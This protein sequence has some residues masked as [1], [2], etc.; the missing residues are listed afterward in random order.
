MKVR[1][2]TVS[3]A[4][5]L[6]VWS[7]GIAVAQVQEE[8]VQEGIKQEQESDKQEDILDFVAPASEAEA[9]QSQLPLRGTL[10]KCAATSPSGRR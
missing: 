5:A 6:A 2:V 1:I 4:V 8:A 10:E 7:G 3:L 9:L